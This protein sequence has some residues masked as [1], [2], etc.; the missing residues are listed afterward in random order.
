MLGDNMGVKIDDET[1]ECSELSLPSTGSY[2]E[3]YSYI[4]KSVVIEDFGDGLVIDD[5]K[6]FLELPIKFVVGRS[7]EIV[8]Q[9]PPGSSWDRVCLSFIPPQPSH[10]EEGCTCIRRYGMVS[11]NSNN[12][13]T[14]SPVVNYSANI[15]SNETY[16]LRY[17]VLENYLLVQFD[18]FVTAEVP[19]STS[20]IE[21]ITMIRLAQYDDTGT[22]LKRFIFRGL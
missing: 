13:T 22:V 6:V 5:R 14:S 21:L 9:V 2:S 4:E 20:T 12:Q 11:F 18:D 15:R 8:L 1:G 7:A 17:K 16:F 3:N 10:I 19:S